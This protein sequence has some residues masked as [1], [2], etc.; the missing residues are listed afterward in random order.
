MRRRSP[1]GL[2][3]EYGFHVGHVYHGELA[4][5][6]IAMMRPLL[7][8]ARDQSPIGGLY[9][10]SAGTRPGGFMTGGNGMR[11]ARRILKSLK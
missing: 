7:G 8:H 2:E 5:D 4:L 11:A 3:S 10:C 1:P 6:Q 9:L